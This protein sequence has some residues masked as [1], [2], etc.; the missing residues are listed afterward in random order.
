M[1][2]ANLKK[3]KYFSTSTTTASKYIGTHEAQNLHQL[4]SPISDPNL[5]N[6]KQ[7]FK[8]GTSHGN[9]CGYWI[10]MVEEAAVAVE[11]ELEVNKVYLLSNP[12][13][14]CFKKLT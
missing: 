3:S 11:V 6:E 2:T 1:A 12:S 4:K 13:Q 7:F 8:H 5:L 10:H 9:G 14:N